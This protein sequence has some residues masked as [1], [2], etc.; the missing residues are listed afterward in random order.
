MLTE[1]TS[2]SPGVDVERRLQPE[3]FALLLREMKRILSE[4][5]EA[6]EKASGRGDPTV[7]DQAQHF[8]ACHGPGQAEALASYLER[9]LEQLQRQVGLLR[10]FCSGVNARTTIADAI[11]NMESRITG[12]DLTL[13]I[14]SQRV[15]EQGKALNTR[16]D[17]SKRSWLLRSSIVLAS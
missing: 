14:L 16:L 2:A 15:E 6:I 9:G 5:A 1:N 12:L 3:Q 4:Q 13:R 17:V 7:A 11:A 8:A 10:S